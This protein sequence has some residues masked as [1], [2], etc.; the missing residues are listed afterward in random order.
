MQC[1]KH[2]N[3]DLNALQPYV[4]GRPV[5]TVAR[6]MGLDPDTIVKLASNENPLGVAPSALDAIRTHAQ[7]AYRYPD[8]GATALR[9]K[10]A[11]RHHVGFDQVI[12]A[13]GS[14]EVL[15]FI[16]HC[17]MGANRSIVCSAHA[18]A[19]YKILATM[20]GSEIIEVPTAGLAHDPDRMLDSIRDDTSVL[21]LCNPNNP[22]GTL[23][24]E[25]Q[26]AR[27]MREVPE[28]VLVVFD[29]AYAEI[30]TASMPDTL[31]Y[32]HEQRNCIVL[33]SFS[34]AY[35]LAGLRVGYGLGAEPLIT[36][37]NKPRQPFNVNRIAQTAA[38]AALDDSEFVRRSR[39]LFGEAADYLQQTC[40]KLDI[41]CQPTTAN[42]ILLDVGDGAGVAQELMARG[43]IVRPMAGYD[44]PRHVRVSFGTMPQ[45]RR[46][47]EELDR[48]RNEGR[49]P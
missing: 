15:E 34:K 38:H 31:W 36:A 2:L 9:T 8:G 6:E 28:H 48:L 14:N 7:H 49:L 37:L 26:I 11:E 35:G 42:Y 24:S 5:E 10:L 12:A 4:P 47:A 25:H 32:V 43:V 33:R 23:L 20:F 39:Q 1:L 22:T 16:G 21:F 44:L 3:C 18:F 45:N 46:L 40:D 27:I 17:F 30:T 29:E 13:A 19:I 41:P